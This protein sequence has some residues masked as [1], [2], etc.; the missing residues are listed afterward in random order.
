MWCGLTPTVDAPFPVGS[1][2]EESIGGDGG[3]IFQMHHT[4]VRAA[5]MEE[6]IEEG[7]GSVGGEGERLM[8]SGYGK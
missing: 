6:T 5:A 7:G 8:T 4:M 2:E 1:L 3:S